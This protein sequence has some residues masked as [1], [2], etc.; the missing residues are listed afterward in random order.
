MQEEKILAKA[1]AGILKE[2]RLSTGKS[3]NLFCNEYSIPTSTLSDLEN[4]KTSIKLY[5][6]YKILKA[7]DY[8]LSDFINELNKKLPDNYLNPEE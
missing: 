2:I 3:L 7:Y 1:V 4:A 5:S 6:L 8:D